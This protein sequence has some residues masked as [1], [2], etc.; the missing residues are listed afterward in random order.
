MTIRDTMGQSAPGMQSLAVLG[1]SV[2]IPKINVPGDW[3]ER[4]SE[5]RDQHLIDF[6]NTAPMT[7]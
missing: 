5:Y 2:G 3:K 1:D 6:W 4:M 7:L